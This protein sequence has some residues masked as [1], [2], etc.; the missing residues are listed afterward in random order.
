MRLGINYYIQ[1]P[2]AAAVYPWLAL[3]GHL[4]P[5]ADINA[6]RYLYGYLRLLSQPSL[7]LARLAGVGNHPALSPAPA[8]GLRYAEKPLLKPHLARAPAVRA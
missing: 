6:R 7:P 4:E 5:R 8:A 3:A 1:V 2:G